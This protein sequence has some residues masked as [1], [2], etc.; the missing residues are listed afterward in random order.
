MSL[1]GYYMQACVIMQWNN[2]WPEI[3][4]IEEM[5]TLI[6]YIVLNQSE[7][8]IDKLR[9]WHH[10]SGMSLLM[11][12][13]KWMFMTCLDKLATNKRINKRDMF[14]SR[15]WNKGISHN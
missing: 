5:K 3:D 13:V 7:L 12:Y 8:A 10:V 9:F 1:H 11:A 6:V 4:T 15:Q 14:A 2:F